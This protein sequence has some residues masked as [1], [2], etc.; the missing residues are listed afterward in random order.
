MMLATQAL[1][2]VSSW[3]HPL[4]SLRASLPTMSPGITAQWLESSDEMLG[5]GG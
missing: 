3:V 5:L 2:R 1:G 4:C